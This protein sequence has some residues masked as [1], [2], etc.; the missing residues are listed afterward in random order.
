MYIRES[1]ERDVSIRAWRDAV[2]IKKVLQL[3]ACADRLCR[4]ASLAVSGVSMGR[5]PQLGQGLTGA[6]Q[7]PLGSCPD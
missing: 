5:S 3:R 6:C 2:G 7:T 4:T 1:N